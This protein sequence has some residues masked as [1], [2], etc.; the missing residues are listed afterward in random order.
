MDARQFANEYIG[1]LKQSGID[2]QTDEKT[3]ALFNKYQERFPELNANEWK[4]IIN[5]L[6][7]TEDI[8]EKRRLLIARYWLREYLAKKNPHAALDFVKEHSAAF[9]DEVG[10]VAVISDALG[11]L[12]KDDPVAAVEWMKKNAAEFPDAMKAQALHNVVHS[13]ARRD[14][15]LAFTLISELGLDYSHAHSAMHTIVTSVTTNEDRTATLAALREYRDANH[16]N[17]ELS[18]A[19][20]R[21]IGYFSRGFQETGIN[22]AKTWISSANL[23]PK[24]LETFCDELSRNYDG[25]E[26]AEWIEWMG[27]TLPPDLSRSPIMDMIGRWTSVDPEA[28]GKWLASAPEGPAKIAATRSYAYA[29]FR[30]DSETAMQWINTLPPGRDRDDTLKA[31]HMNWPKDDPEAAAA[32]AK[33]HGIKQAGH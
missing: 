6:L 28:A 23:T 18:S 14:P 15:G 20:N 8:D 19:A 4:I 16:Q 13:T 21:M 3:K 10:V 29:I 22:G 30:H 26:H 17:K 32:F 24:E 25:G 11:N 31:I 7:D 2:G 27:A 33:E 9:N 1:L 5:T 12:A